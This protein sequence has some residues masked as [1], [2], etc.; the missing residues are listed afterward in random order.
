M[1]YYHLYDVRPERRARAISNLEALRKRLDADIPSKDAEDNLL[2]ATW[3]IRDLGKSNRRGFGERLPESLIYIAEIISRFDFVAVQEVNDIEE[4]EKILSILGRDWDWIS[5]DVTDRR[6]GGNGERLTFAYDKRRVQFQHV[7]GEIVLPESMLISPTR[8][9]T[10]DGEAFWAGKQFRRSPYIARFK[11]G[12]LDFEICTVHIYYGSDS[13]S[14]PKMAQRVQEIERIA[15]YL[16]NRAKDQVSD[17]RALLLLGDFNIVAPGHKTMEALLANDFV[18]P[19]ALKKRTN[20]KNTHYYDQIAFHSATELV[21]CADE[22]GA[23]GKANAGVLDLFV[24][25]MTDEQASIY[26][27]EMLESSNGKN[28]QTSES[29]GNADALERYFQTWR[30]YQVSD[31]KPMWVRLATDGSTTYLQKLAEEVES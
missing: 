26:R 9:E 30:T 27:E 5:S 15:E 16:G 17:R 10:E 18:V 6:L 13:E 4:W 28:K 7:A 22:K 20:V 1:L 31:H 12:W 23:D 24:S 3:N 25:C 2:L 21:R 14:S 11:S 8:L 19:D 29:E